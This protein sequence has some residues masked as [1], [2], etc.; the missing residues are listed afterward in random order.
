MIRNVPPSIHNKLRDI[1]LANDFCGVITA[2][3]VQTLCQAAD[4]TVEQLMLKLLECARLYAQPS[5]SNYYVGAVTQGLTGNLYFG[6]NLEFTEQA[7]SFTVHGEQAAVIQA[8]LHEESGLKALAVGGTPCG[9][10]RQ[11]I[12]ELVTAAGIKIFTPQ[13]KPL[14]LQAILPN[15]FGPHSLGNSG[16]LMQPEA[17]HLRLLDPT[18]DPLTQAALTMANKSYAPYSKSYSGAAILTTTGQIFAGPYAENVAFNPSLSPLQAALVHLNMANQTTETIR[19]AILV[20]VKDAVCSQVE[21]SRAVLNS[22][23]NVVL[24]VVYAR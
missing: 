2:E 20:E 19:K 23:S 15:A 18:D 13:Q 8:W 22:V 21:A 4:L 7:L 24:E 1:L 14:P 16:G 10:C 5:I 9:H 12:A 11:F 3:A 17:H 6:A